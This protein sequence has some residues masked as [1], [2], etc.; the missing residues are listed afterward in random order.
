M[1][2]SKKVRM[3]E[4]KMLGLSERRV[5]LI[6]IAVHKAVEEVLQDPE[7]KD[8]VDGEIQEAMLGLL[9]RGAAQLTIKNLKKKYK[10]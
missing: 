10:N 2:K 3:S 6:S 1:A 7:L 9:K 8:L 5:N 4:E